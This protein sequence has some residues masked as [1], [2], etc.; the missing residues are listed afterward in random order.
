MCNLDCTYCYYLHK[1]EL[2]PHKM[3][4]RI[5][6]ELLEEFIRQ[7]IAGQ[8]VDDIR[9]NWHGGEPALMGLDFYRKIIQLQQKYAGTKR[10]S[11]EFQTNGVLLDECWCEFLK[12]KDKEDKGVRESAGQS[13]HGVADARAAQERNSEPS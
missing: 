2:L 7:Y 12:D 3:A 13:R 6:D 8:D 9:F 11:N 5:D 1:E 4:D 10:I